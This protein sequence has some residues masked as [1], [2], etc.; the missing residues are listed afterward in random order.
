M[1]Q[2]HTKAK[3]RISFTHG[4]LQARQPTKGL[5]TK[6]RK[7]ANGPLPECGCRSSRAPHLDTLDESTSPHPTSHNHTNHDQ[8]CTTQISPAACTIPSS[9]MLAM[10]SA[11]A[12]R[13]PRSAHQVPIRA[14][15]DTVFPASNSSKRQ[16]FARTS[17]PC[18]LQI[19]G[20]AAAST[21][22]LGVQCCCCKEERST[23]DHGSG[24]GLL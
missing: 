2:S 16:H 8:P 20:V 23:I 21:A 11:L 9:L 12:E 14:A 22:A 13:L 15:D 4:M 5:V 7:Y 19:V 10:S 3:I 24:L 1:P 17:S 18:P 6:L